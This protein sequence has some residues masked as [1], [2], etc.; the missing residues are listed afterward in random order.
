[1]IAVFVSSELLLNIVSGRKVAYRATAKN[2]ASIVCQHCR[3]KRERVMMERERGTGNRESLKLGIFINQ[4]I[5]KT[6][7]VYKSGNL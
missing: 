6:G 2:A 1:M 4:G 7:Y 3:Y 5:F